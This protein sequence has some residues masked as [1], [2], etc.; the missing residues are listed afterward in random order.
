MSGSNCDVVSENGMRWN[1]VRFGNVCYVEIALNEL[2]E[3]ISLYTMNINHLHQ[4]IIF[5]LF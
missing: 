1:R 5:N 2:D 3:V 4:S